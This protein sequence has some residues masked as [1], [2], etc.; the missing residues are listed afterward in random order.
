MHQ[1][2]KKFSQTV[3][4]W[5]LKTSEV[6]VHKFWSSNIP[7]GHSTSPWWKMLVLIALSIFQ[8]QMW[9]WYFWRQTYKN[10]Q[11]GEEGVK[12]GRRE[13]GLCFKT[14]TKISFGGGKDSQHKTPEH[15]LVI[16]ALLLQLL[17]P[18]FPLHNCSILNF[19]FPATSLLY[20][21]SLGSAW[22]KRWTNTL[23]LKS[24]P[25]HS[26]SFKALTF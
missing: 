18:T 13:I 24:T 16:S 20:F 3:F 9:T 22:S 8:L 2:I 4:W 21:L 6:P 7:I 12:V 5:Q 11:I 26:Y 17:T 23:I 10:M 15:I 1:K 14:I 25:R 19:F